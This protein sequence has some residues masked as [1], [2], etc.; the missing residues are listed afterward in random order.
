MTQNQ[1][2]QLNKIYNT[3]ALIQ[4]GGE[5]TIVM[6]TCLSAMKELITEAGAE[7]EK[8][9]NSSLMFNAHCVSRSIVF[10]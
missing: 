9:E 10:L 4:T 7:M 3:L 2:I 8:E 5:N 6:G 1:F